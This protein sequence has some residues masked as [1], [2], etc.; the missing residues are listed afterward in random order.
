[1]VVK[2]K[3]LVKYKASVH[4]VRANLIYKKCV[5]VIFK[6]NSKT[7]VQKLKMSS[8]TLDEKTDLKYQDKCE[9]VGRAVR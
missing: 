4:G 8:I 7:V 9:V 3:T 2:S 6:L 1:M 5:T